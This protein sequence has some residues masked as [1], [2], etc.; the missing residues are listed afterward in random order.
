MGPRRHGGT[1]I[2][3]QEQWGARGPSQCKATRSPVKSSRP[4]S[5]HLHSHRTRG[6]SWLACPDPGGLLLTTTGHRRPPSAPARQ[7]ALPSA[8]RYREKSCA[9]PFRR[10]PRLSGPQAL[11]LQQG[12]PTDTREKQH[13]EKYMMPNDR[14]SPR[15]HS[16]CTRVLTQM[17]MHTHSPRVGG[18]EQ[19]RAGGPAVSHSPPQAGTDNRLHF[20]I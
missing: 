11:A 6:Q 17:H 13:K 4:L 3:F 10:P 8:E 16:P 18:G 12:S 19:H 5:F 14:P 20:K 15:M 7:L 9:A 2:L 1:S